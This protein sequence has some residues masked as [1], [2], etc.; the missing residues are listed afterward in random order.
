MPNTELKRKYDASLKQETC[1]ADDQL[2][3]LLATVVERVCLETG[4]DGAAIALCGPDGV[5]CRAS[6]G[7]APAVGSRLEIDSSFTRECFESGQAVLCEDAENDP[8]VQRSIAR[9][10]RLR[11]A[12]AVPIQAQGLVLGIAEVFSS[13]LSAFTSHTLMSYSASSIYSLLFW[14]QARRKTRNLLLGAR[15]LSQPRWGGPRQEKT[16][17]RP[18]RPWSCS[19]RSPWSIFHQR[20]PGLR[21]GNPLLE[22]SQPASLGAGIESGLPLSCGSP[23][24]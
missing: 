22:P 21:K 24:R 2:S 9:S 15:P 10:L 6:T 18:N 17:P 1:K 20:L 23:L 13:R 14:L 19:L 5:L 4:A 11:S 12:L 3:V 7:D 16:G 8:R